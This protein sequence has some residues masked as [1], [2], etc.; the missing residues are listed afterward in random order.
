MTQDWGIQKKMLYGV[1][2]HRV[3]MIHKGAFK[4]YIMPRGWQGVRKSP[5]ICYI[6]IF[7][8]AESVTGGGWVSKITKKNVLCNI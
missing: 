1:T 5:K 6:F 3:E 7:F 4:Y 2:E 8:S